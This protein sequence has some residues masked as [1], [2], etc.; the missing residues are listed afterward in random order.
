MRKGNE[1]TWLILNLLQEDP[2]VKAF[3]SF[4][5]VLLKN[6]RSPRA[7]RPGLTESLQ[8]RVLSKGTELTSPSLYLN[9]SLRPG[10]PRRGIENCVQEEAK[11]TD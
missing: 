8:E 9:L 11:E 4:L 5:L 7:R 10:I 3:H 1:L 6:I 2:C